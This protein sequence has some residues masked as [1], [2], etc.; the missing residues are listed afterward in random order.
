MLEIRSPI[1]KLIIALLLVTL[2]VSTFP[3]C[4]KE[5]LNQYKNMEDRIDEYVEAF[6]KTVTD[7]QING[8]ILIARNDEIL[9]NNSYG[10]AD[11]ENNIAFTDDTI[12]RL[13][14]VTKMLTS[15]AIMQLYESGNLDLQDPV[16]KYIPEQHRGDDITI[17]DLLSHTSGIV[18]DSGVNATRFNTKE[19]IINAISKQPLLFEP[20]TKLSYSNSD[21]NL[22]AAI[23]ERV[24]ETTYSDYMEKNIFVPANMINTG[25]DSSRD[26]IPNLAVGYGYNYGSFKKRNDLDLSFAFGAGEIYSTAK[27]LYNFDISLH[28][29]KLISE[30]LVEKMFSN[31]SGFSELGFA[32]GYG[33]TLGDLNGHEW[34]GHPGNLP[35]WASYYARFPEENTTVIILLNTWLPFNHQLKDAIG[36]IAIGEEYILPAPKEE[37]KLDEA[38]LEKYEGKYEAEVGTFIHLR[39]NNYVQLQ[40]M[41]NQLFDFQTSDTINLIPFSEKEF[42][43]KGLEFIEYEFETDKDGNVLSLVVRNSVEEIRFKKVK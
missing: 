29:G 23:I 34:Y 1:K 32:C 20:G 30:K 28:E 9:V 31:T 12:F 35:N 42:Y 11:Y 18:R 33:S 16:S 6:N 22:L 39:P 27:D 43:V 21:F 41:G 13:C 37:I 8:T 15:V 25:C 40:R 24:S 5:S 38:L 10:K 19:E 36:A 4:T 3:G 2:S 17:H 7:Y 14:S 26:K